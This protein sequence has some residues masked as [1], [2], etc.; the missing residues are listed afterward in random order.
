MVLGILTGCVCF[1]QALSVGVIGGAR[2]SGDLTGA[3]ATSVSKRY[4]FGPALELDLLLGLG[5]EV[6]A[7]YRRQGYETSFSNFASSIVAGERANSWEFP[8]LI[9]YR[10]PF[11]LVRPFVEGGYAPRTIRGS[12][13]SVNSPLPPLASPT[14][15]STAGTNWPVSHGLVAGAGVRFG[16]GRLRLAPVIRYTHWN[17]AAISGSYPDGPAWQSTQNQLDLLVGI[18]WKIR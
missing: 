6:N 17:N 11:P 13:T 8:V 5:V 1:G 14:V 7:L 18:G 16:I 12:I 15:R 2:A 4:V 10:L 3:G 9:K